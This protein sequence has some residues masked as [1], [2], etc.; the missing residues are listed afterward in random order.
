MSTLTKRLALVRRI[1]GK[2]G[3][4]VD[5]DQRA[6]LLKALELDLAG[7]GGG[8][9]ELLMPKVNLDRR[10]LEM[11]ARTYE[12]RWIRGRQGGP[13]G[14]PVRLQVREEAMSDE[15]IVFLVV[16]FVN[17]V[18]E[19][20]IPPAKILRRFVEWLQQEAKKRGSAVYKYLA[21]NAPTLLEAERSDKWWEERLRAKKS[22]VKK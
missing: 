2:H 8:L 18:G 19:R 10:R 9:V 7:R 4:I 22:W 12:T 21:R 13:R 1:S 20:D 3:S 5:Q 6:I 17:F 16:R 14:L 11:L 15:L